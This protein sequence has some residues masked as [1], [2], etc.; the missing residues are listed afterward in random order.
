MPD[1]AAASVADTIYR[2]FFLAGIVAIL[3]VGA[4]WGAWLLWQIGF[5]GSFT[6]ISVHA[7]NAHGHAQI[8]GWVCLFIMGF[9]YQAFPRI[10]H[11]NLPAPRLA[12]V[13]FGL[14]V[15]GI[16][17][18]TLGMTLSESWAA[19]VPAAIGGAALELIAV[20]IF[21]GQIAVAFRRGGKPL[22][23]YVAFVLAAL[24]F[25]IVQTL[26]GA[27]H[28]YMTM[29]AATKNELLW[30]VS[31]YQAPL[32]DLQIHGLAMF[33]ILGVSLRMLPPLFE[34]PAT[35]ARRAWIGFSILFAAVIG[36]TVI[37]IVYRWSDNY[38]AAAFLMIPWLMLAGGVWLVAA[39]W[40]LWRPMPDA[41]RS[42]KFVRAAYAW[43]AVSLIM[44]LLLPVYQKASGIA[45]SHAYY[46]A[47]RHAITVGFISLMIMG[48]AAKVVP[49]LNGIDTKQFSALWL[50][51][52]LVNVGCFL[53]CFTQTMTDFYPGFF[54]VVGVS[55]TLEVTGLAIWGVH[56]ARIILR[57]KSE[58]QRGPA[59]HCITP[60]HHVADVLAWFPQT[61]QVFVDFGF[62]AVRN[63]ALRNTVARV[64]TLRRGAA[65]SGID[66]DTFVEALNAAARQQI[67]PLTVK[68][69]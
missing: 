36:E 5:G 69:G 67:I 61:E 55:G 8:F 50:P 44:L 15:V 29:T 53:R 31:T 52:V 58:A 48:F 2:R 19:A 38:A 6:S 26:F 47:I 51:F 56:L 21:V 27:W 35:P 45:F 32:R 13:A 62:T 18:R 33:M 49:T 65:M 46:G 22:E 20:C 7:V 37:F 63:L 10:W 39:P 23:P 57:G 68:G 28:T 25:M 4:T 59:P 14:L 16:I 64:T 3:T 30:Y 24:T 41:D 34:V 1:I 54:W 66:L 11:V 42:G 60:D 17:V 12:V 43:L 9:G 40:K